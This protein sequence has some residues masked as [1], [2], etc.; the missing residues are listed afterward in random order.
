MAVA[1]FRRMQPDYTVGSFRAER[2]CANAVCDAQRER[3]FAGLHKAGLP[4]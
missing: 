3:F 4:D 2:L 1:E